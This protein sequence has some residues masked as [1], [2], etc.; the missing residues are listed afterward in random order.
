MG[1]VCQCGNRI[2]LAPDERDRLTATGNKFTCLNCGRSGTLA[3]K[4]VVR[5]NEREK[6]T[7]RTEISS[8]SVN[9][10]FGLDAENESQ[11]I[12]E[13]VV[14][15]GSPTTPRGL[16]IP[17][18][19]SRSWRH[20]WIIGGAVV[21]GL[22]AIVLSR[23]PDKKRPL[24]PTEI[25]K[26]EASLSEQPEVP[27]EFTVLD[28][29]TKSVAYMGVEHR[30]VI[31][32]LENPQTKEQVEAACQ[33]LYGNY[34]RDIEAAQP[35]ATH[36][37]LNILVYDSFDD[38]RGRTDLPI[39][40]ARGPNSGAAPQLPEWEQVKLDWHWRHSE[41]RPS[42]EKRAVYRAYIRGLHD[43]HR[44]AEEPFTDKDG[45][46][47]VKPEDRPVVKAREKVE[48]QKLVHRMCQNHKLSR[49]E[50][51]RNIAYVSLW[52]FGAKPTEDA[53][54]KSSQVELRRWAE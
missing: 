47:Q 32:V 2:E 19:F 24:L 34:K 40:Q 42:D 11:P 3:A 12:H 28:V 5:S 29:R 25:G 45:I 44:I 48:E 20:C 6:H 41:F 18:V 27:P 37:L 8:N 23:M 9:A 39:C 38:A 15:N 17:F 35:N 51:A 4:K 52:S 14:Q 33:K 10:L 7:S 16:T 54:E 1:L 30:S 43:A 36:K 31:V 46:I 21:L 50:L 49:A 13:P 26:P 53:V 22:V